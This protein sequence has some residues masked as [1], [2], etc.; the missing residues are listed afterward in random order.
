MVDRMIDLIRQHYTGDFNW[1]S[2]RQGRVVVL[3]ARREDHAQLEEYLMREFFGTPVV[4][5][6]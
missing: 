5:R 2:Q 1:R 4:K 6:Q 3:S